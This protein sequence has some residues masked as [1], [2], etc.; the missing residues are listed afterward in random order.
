MAL[1]LRSQLWCTFENS[2][3]GI[4]GM[5]VISAVCAHAWTCRRKKER[6]ARRD[7][8]DA[9]KMSERRKLIESWILEFSCRCLCKEF[10]KNDEE[11]K[12]SDIM[13]SNF[14]LITGMSAASYV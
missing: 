2:A 9:I 8:E 13:E 6:T 10:V 14:K 4:Q 11:D 5:K 3:A 7:R 12:M 1:E